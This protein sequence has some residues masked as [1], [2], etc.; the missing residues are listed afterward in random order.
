MKTQFSIL[1]GLG[2]LTVSYGS[3]RVWASGAA[4]F[5]DEVL[6]ARS[7]GGGQIGVAGQSDDPA[8]IYFNPAGM[9]ALPGTQIT[10]G[11]TAIDLNG[12]YRSPFGV[13]SKSINGRG[14]VPNFAVTQRLLDDRLSIGFAAEA[15]Y[16]FKS[17][18][19]A[20]GPLRYVATNSH[21]YMVDLTP[22][23]AYQFTPW[24][25]AG[26]AADFFDAFDVEQS[27]RVANFGG[28]PDGNSELT[29]QGTSWGF[30]GGVRIT[31]NE[32]HTLGIV[33]HDKVK[34]T[35]KGTA[36]LD[37]LSAPF[38]TIMGGSHYQTAIYTDLF[39]PQNIQLGYA[40][41]P[42]SRWT[43]E[44][45]AAWYDWDSNRDLDVRFAESDPNRLAVLNT[46][47]PITLDRR[48][49]WGLTSGANYRFSERWQVRGGFGYLPHA[50]PDWV[51]QPAINDL[52]RF[53][54]CVGAGWT[55]APRWTL[56]FGYSIVFTRTRHIVGNPNPQIDGD[57]SNLIHLFVANITLR[58]PQRRTMD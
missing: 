40:Y 27:R 55:F 58:L 1:V 7:V 24:I 29:A 17:N 16:G 39:I 2:L 9:T 36:S 49:A 23:V 28:A 47:N 44:L 42:D 35:V 53:G 19:P 4:A 41:R 3:S 18:W 33:Y 15:P 8:T 38:D 31:P 13:E 20:D 52:T 34:L 56:D 14:V 21:L 43:L 22:A 30:H 11:V 57:Y 32:H 50:T 54:M 12:K 46:G 6:S 10:L 51:Y 25:S 26:V 5:G 37:G 48:S 45:D